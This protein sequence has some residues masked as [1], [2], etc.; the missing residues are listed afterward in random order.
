MKES[1][2]QK[3]KK[4]DVE[5]GR[6]LFS[7]AKKNNIKAPPSPLQARILDYLINNEGKKEICQKDIED[8]FNVSKATI[9]CALQAMENSKIIIREIS[10][11]DARSKKINLTNEYQNIHKDMQIVF[12][13]LDKEL[14]NGITKEE[15]ECFIKILEKM[16]NN[17]ED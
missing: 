5:I 11:N 17:M 10:T 1:L 7:I 8:N 13:I 12:N 16:E 6:K 15:L 2:A 4:L 14:I 3:L 9:S